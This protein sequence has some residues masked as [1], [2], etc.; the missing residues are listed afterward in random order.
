[1][2]IH[3]IESH[4][5]FPDMSFYD[6][7]KPG[8][9]ALYIAHCDLYPFR[10]VIENN[11]LALD[12]IAEGYH[13]MATEA[14][15]QDDFVTESWAM[16]SGL[17]H[18]SRV[19]LYTQYSLLLT[20]VSILEEA[21]N[22]LCRVHMNMKYLTKQLKDIK[23]S[24][25]ERAVKYLK[26]VVGITGFMADRQWE[27]ITAIRDARNM[28]VHNGGRLVRD[29]DKKNYREEDK[30]LYLDYADIVKRYEVILEFIDRTFRLEI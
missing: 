11:K 17:L 21:V 26:D 4:V 16:T 2:D 9:M 28:V 20:M 19:R 22:T 24:G 14:R 7:E 1:M 27:Y 3:S 12:M 15:E 5:K 10:S 13:Q 29:F 23:G 30:Q 8:E 6:M 25:L 18:T